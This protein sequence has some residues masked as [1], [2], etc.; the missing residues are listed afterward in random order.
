MG[1]YVAGTNCQNVS[2][3]F[4]ILALPSAAS[5]SGTCAQYDQATPAVP[6]SWNMAGKY[7]FVSYV[8]ATEVQMKY[9]CND[10][11]CSS[12]TRAVIQ[13]FGACVPNA[14]S[15]G[16]DYVIPASAFP[17]GATTAV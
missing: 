15:G 14:V 5:R 6:A 4:P 2:A 16:P 11:A 17:S 12:C 8:S 1:Y 10:N 9:P 13:Q 7:F 3:A